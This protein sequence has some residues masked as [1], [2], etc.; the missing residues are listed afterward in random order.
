MDHYVAYHSAHVMGRPY[1]AGDSLN[2][3][4][5]KPEAVLRK[6]L[7][8]R[9]WVVA[10][11]RQGSR[12]T[13]AL[14]GV[15][16]CT[17]VERDGDT[18]IVDGPGAT[19]QAAITLNHLGWF[20]ELREEQNNFSLGFNPIRSENVIAELER[21]LSS[22]GLETHLLGTDAA[23]HKLAALL[24]DPTVR[25]SLLRKFVDSMRFIRERSTTQRSQLTY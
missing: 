20:Q 2:F 24:P 13:Y 18:C 19:F 9:V 5:S 3:L 4:S 25:D 23:A 7:G 21:L 12:T 15:Y 17:D 14:A 16:T 6:A 1:V 8:A 22:N 10:G 11:E